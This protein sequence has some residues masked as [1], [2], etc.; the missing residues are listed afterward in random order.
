MLPAAA[1]AQIGARKEYAARVLRGVA[2]QV[3]DAKA[4]CRFHPV[5]HRRNAVAAI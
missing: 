5:K 1:L 3:A 4:I 2:R